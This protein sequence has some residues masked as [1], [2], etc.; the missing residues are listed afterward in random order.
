MM[1]PRRRPAC[2]RVKPLLLALLLTAPLPAWA[3][4]AIHRCVGADG[5]PIFTDQ[6]CAAL[7]ATP[8]VPSP[9]A[10][11]AEPP[12]GVLCA[13]DLEDLRV[14]LSRAFATHDANRVG[15][16][17]LWNGYGRNGAVDTL[18]RMESLVKQPLLSVD[19]DER[20]GIE[21]VAGTTGATQQTHFGVTRESGCLWLRPPG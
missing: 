5:N 14:G 18:K 17:V 9:V 12:A 16:L 10:T 20:S 19:G 3:Q 7:G 1:A 6:P 15:A 4:D 8:A 13:S 11:A 21:V 2:H